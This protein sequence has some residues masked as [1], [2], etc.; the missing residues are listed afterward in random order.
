[1]EV[2]SRNVFPPIR[3][4]PYLL[5]MG[6][7]GHFWFVLQSQREKRNTK[8][9]VVPSLAAEANLQTLLARRAARRDWNAPF[10]PTICAAAAGSAPRRVRFAPCG[11]SSRSRSL[12]AGGSLMAFAG[13]LR[14][15]RAGDLFA[16]GANRDGRGRRCARPQCSASRHRAHRTRDER[17]LYDAIWDADFREKLFQLMA[18]GSRLK[19][20][21][22][23]VDGVKSDLLAHGA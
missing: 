20:E 15:W 23:P 5:T 19:G 7:H 11:S 14:R 1:M 17:V 21:K 10:C 6:P 2:F 3:K 18:T 8:K 9:R 4:S 12:R 16:A 13:R 22:R